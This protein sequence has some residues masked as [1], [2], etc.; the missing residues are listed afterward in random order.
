VE[1]LRKEF[2]AVL[3]DR[4]HPVREDFPRLVNTNCFMK[5]VFRKYPVAMGVL[6]Q[7]GEPIETADGRLPTGVEVMI[8]LYALHHH[9]DFW[10]EPETFDPLR[11]RSTATPRVPY[12]YVPF[13]TGARQCLGRHLAEMNFVVILHA[14]LRNYEIDVLDQSAR[15][16]RYLI[17]RFDRDIPCAVRPRRRDPLS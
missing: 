9:P 17:P 11:W 16:N 7:T 10:E 5:E 13:L 15:M 2:D 1:T 3:G 6:R 4:S 12:S 14:L 8:L